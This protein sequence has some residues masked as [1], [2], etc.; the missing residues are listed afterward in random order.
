MGLPNVNSG[1]FLF[2]LSKYSPLLESTKT[3]QRGSQSATLP[4]KKI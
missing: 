1:R 3:V 4:H 2:N